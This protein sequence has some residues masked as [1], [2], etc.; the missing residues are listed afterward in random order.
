MIPGTNTYMSEQLSSEIMAIRQAYKPNLTNHR[1]LEN[2]KRFKHVCYNLRDPGVDKYT[3]PPELSQKQ[4][5]AALKDAPDTY[6]SLGL[7]DG[8]SED[9]ESEGGAK[10]KE[11]GPGLVPV[12]VLGFKGLKDRISLQVRNTAAPLI[13]LHARSHQGW[14]AIIIVTGRGH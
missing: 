8:D 6:A 13:L 7:S 9:D 11:A 14:C 2:Y 3:K 4:W 12:A 1:D 5:E 10:T